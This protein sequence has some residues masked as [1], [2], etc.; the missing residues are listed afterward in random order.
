MK[1]L[2]RFAFLLLTFL[3][4]LL[5]SNGTAFSRDDCPTFD[6]L[7]VEDSIVVIKIPCS[8]DASVKYENYK[9]NEDPTGV[10]LNIVTRQPKIDPHEYDFQ[11]AVFDKYRQKIDVLS[12]ELTEKENMLLKLKYSKE[13]TEKENMLLKLKYP[14]G[15]KP[16]M[17]ALEMEIV[18]LR[19]KE[20][21]LRNE[22]NLVSEA[23]FIG[24]LDLIKIQVPSADMDI[25]R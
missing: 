25:K 13:L 6:T 5:T 19:A 21:T 15:D 22:I 24:V 17:Q 20:R 14:K 12:R 1:T 4:L 16:R 18:A 23:L 7:I 11:L 2:N 10:P 8:G 9:D 3:L